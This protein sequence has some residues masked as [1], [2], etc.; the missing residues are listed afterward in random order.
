MSIDP[1]PKVG[2][3]PPS[4]V[5]TEGTAP[6]KKP[7]P[8]APVG[9]LQK[10]N[11]PIAGKDGYKMP[12]GIGADGTGKVPSDSASLLSKTGYTWGLNSPVGEQ[13]SSNTP[14]D[15]S[16]VRKAKDEKKKQNPK[17]DPDQP[18]I[19]SQD[20][21]KNVQDAFMSANPQSLGA[22]LVK[23]MQSMVMLKMMNKLTSPAGI[24]SMSSGG[25]GGALQGV[26]G[27]VGLGSMMGALNQVMIPL[28]TSGLLNGSA[29]DALHAGMVGMMNNTAVGALSAQEI[30]AAQSTVS[31][32]AYA[33]NAIAT[34]NASG[35]V[36]AIASFGG[37]A[38]G[39]TPGSLAARIALVGPS[40]RIQSSGIYNGVR[41]YTTIT[42][43]PNPHL[44]N[45]IPILTG[46]E[47]VSIATAAVSVIAGGL[48]DALGIDNPVGSTLNFV[49]K[50]S[51]TVS[52]L[53][54][55]AGLISGFPNINSFTHNA[56][57]SIINSGIDNIVSSGLNKVLGVPTSGLLGAATSLLPAIGGDIISSI[58]EAP[59]A[60]VNSGKIN[61]AMQ[62]ATKALA[63]SRAG[64]NVAQNIFGASRAEQI[65]QAIDSSSNLAAA[66]GG[67]INMVTAFGDII[68]SAPAEMQN[69]M[70]TA[71]TQYAVGN[72]L[73]RL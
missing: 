17:L 62:N 42:T 5:E 29:T 68:H 35:A 49:S 66:V 58:S 6:D 2:A 57:G 21:S 23:A 69:K 16:A 38:F 43:S 7:N 25:I 60:N 31:T 14:T 73:I 47:H 30:A 44:T 45:N 34:G 53:T 19:V 28:S 54:A 37:P 12:Q 32:V 40:G 22:V 64:Y 9:P 13:Q 3:T 18:T 55:G 15:A 56:F 51:G 52:D 8:S 67:A 33:M 63:L 4:K 39:L 65:V 70:V 72:G 11:N 24:N 10:L 41:I 20:L 1:N 71:G 48:S 36:D 61:Q 46:A 59:L 26:A 50:A 27:A